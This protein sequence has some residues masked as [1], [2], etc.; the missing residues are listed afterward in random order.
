MAERWA[1][2]LLKLPVDANPGGFTPGVPRGKP[3][4]NSERT[5]DAHVHV[6]TEEGRELTR[7]DNSLSRGIELPETKPEHCAGRRR[8][9]C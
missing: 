2:R 7:R 9:T 5:D 3:R 4:K 6:S 1:E 8:D